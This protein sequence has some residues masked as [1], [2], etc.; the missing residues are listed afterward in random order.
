MQLKTVS[1]IVSDFSL[2]I[3]YPCI[4]DTFLCT[5][6]RNLQYP[7]MNQTVSL[8]MSRYL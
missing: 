3:T 4:A 8:A 6:S 7:S 2:W 1:V 5:I